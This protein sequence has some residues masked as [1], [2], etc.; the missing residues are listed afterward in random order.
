MPLPTEP[1]VNELSPD[2][3]RLLIHG[4]PGAGKTTFAS[5]W[6]PGRNL[7]IDVEGGTRFIQGA[8]VVRPSNFTEF[9]STVDELVRGGHKFKTVTV[10]TV[11]ALGRMADLEAGQRYSKVA[12]GVVEYGKG[13]ADRDATI[14]RAINKLIN[15]DLGLILIAHSVL[16]EDED[17]NEK[18]VPSVHAKDQRPYYLGNVDFVW[19]ARRN[20]PTGDLVTQPNKKYE[21]KSRLNVP[22]PLPLDAKAA[23]SALSTACATKKKE[24]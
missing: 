15:S 5:Q 13:T 18:W 16:V 8:H 10:D 7:L 20:G 1:L 4:A 12:A 24:S 3:A 22:S 9:S 21:V 14:F 11:N 2:R 19:F 23:Y 6:D 17:E